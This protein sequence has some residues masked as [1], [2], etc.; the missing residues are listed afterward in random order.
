[1]L[2]GLVGGPVDAEDGVGAGVAGGAGEGVGAAHEDGVGVAEQDDGDLGDLLAHGLAQ[3]QGGAQAAPRLE[4]APH[5]LLDGGA[6]GGG[7]APGDAELQ[8]IGAG[9]GGGH[10][11]AAAGLEVGVGGGEVDDQG[12]AP[13]GAGPGEGGGDT[14]AHR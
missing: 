12:L 13:L 1:E 8:H 6:V 3:R 14:V 5:G 10:Q 7:I 2:G 9:A 4:S 11:Q